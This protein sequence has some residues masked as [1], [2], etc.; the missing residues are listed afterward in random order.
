[1]EAQLRALWA[2]R[3]SGVVWGKGVSE[4]KGNNIAT[5]VTDISSW[6]IQPTAAST[7]AILAK[8]WNFLVA[9]SKK[10]KKV[11][12]ASQAPV[13]HTCNPSYLG[14]WDGENR[15]SKPAQA[16]NLKDSLSQ[17]SEQNGLQ[18]WLKQYS[19]W[20]ASARPW[21]QTP[22]PPKKEN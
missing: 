19:T 13:A 10:Y 4:V 3:I 15:G 18:V 6:D 20:F 12:F 1:M 16:N 9:Y 22:I 21:V 11:S 5:K 14:G 8:F 7:I 2:S 17:T